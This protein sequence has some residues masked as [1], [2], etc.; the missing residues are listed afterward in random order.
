MAGA[1]EVVIGAVSPGPNLVFVGET[2]LTLTSARFISGTSCVNLISSNS[3]LGIRCGD[4][5]FGD[6]RIGGGV[7]GR[8]SSEGKVEGSDGSLEGILG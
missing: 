6:W 2:V 4:S 5:S 8:S 7:R 1:F 3:R